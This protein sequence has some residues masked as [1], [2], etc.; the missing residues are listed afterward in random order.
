M[1]DLISRKSAIDLIEEMKPHHQDADDI[2]EMIANMPSAQPDLQPTCNQLATDCISRQA[3]IDIAMQY[4][5]DDDGSCSKAGADIRELLDEFENLPSA[6][7]ERKKGKWRLVTKPTD[8]F[9]GYR[10]SE[11]NELVYGKTNYCPRCGAEMK[12]DAN[13]YL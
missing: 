6:Q 2:A 3:A 10:C 5:P 13:E 8:S 9:A 7:P 1:D 11:C 4:C 12:G